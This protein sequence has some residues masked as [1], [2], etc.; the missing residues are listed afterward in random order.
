MKTTQTIQNQAKERQILKPQSI[1]YYYKNK[2]KKTQIKTTIKIS[3]KTNRKTITITTHER[4]EQKTEYKQ[5][6]IKGSYLV[7]V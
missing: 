2:Y 1:T 7:L 5:E 4:N 3:D 6:K